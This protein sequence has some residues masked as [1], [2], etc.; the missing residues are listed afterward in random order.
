MKAVVRPGPYICA[1][2]D[3]GGIPSW[4]NNYNIRRIWDKEY[5]E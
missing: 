4:L 2:I 3:N 5:R 1:E